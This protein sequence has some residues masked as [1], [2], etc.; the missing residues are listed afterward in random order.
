MASTV[1]KLNFADLSV[2][3]EV[4]FEAS[5]TADDID[6]FAAVSG[7]VSPLHVDEGFARSRGFGGRVVHGAH[8]TALV[9]RLVGV[10]LP[11]A[12]CL[13][14][15]VAMQFRAPVL[16]G[17]RLSVTGTVDQLSEAVRTAILKVAVR[18]LGS[19]AVV[20]TAKVTV[21]FT[22]PMAGRSAGG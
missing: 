4:G 2:G 12:N 5:V 7:D 9:S 6:R 10:H 1:A 8:L 13:L 22:V 17:A 3:Q 15:A 16:A 20:A 14:Q 11:G 19:G 18:D 21:G